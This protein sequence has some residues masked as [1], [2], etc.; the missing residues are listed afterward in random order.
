LQAPISKKLITTRSGRVTQGAGP[1]FKPQ[2]WEKKKR[3]M[4]DQAHLFEPVLYGSK[5]GTPSF[6]GLRGPIGSRHSAVTSDEETDAQG[7]HFARWPGVQATASPAH[8]SFRHQH[9][10]Q[11]C[12]GPVPSLPT[13]ILNPNASGSHPAAVPTYMTGV[14]DWWH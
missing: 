3:W 12:Q 13:A 1:E 8:A 5:K 10:S 11:L 4:T 6:T 2:S 7:G 14:C 9:S